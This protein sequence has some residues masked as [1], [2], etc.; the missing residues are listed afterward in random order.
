MDDVA[1]AI[2]EPNRREI[3]RLVRDDELSAGQI[4]ANFEISRP[5]VSQHLGVLRT[6]GLV[7]ERRAGTRRLYRARPEG[8]AGLRD[9]LDDFWSNRLERLGLAAE[10]E[11][12]KKNARKKRRGKDAKRRDSRRRRA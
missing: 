3:L 7:E 4:A 1:R 5:A 12:S 8:M 2:A 10:L 9:F 11:Q 6:A